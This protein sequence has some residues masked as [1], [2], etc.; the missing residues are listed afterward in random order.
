M[1]TIKSIHA[2]EIIDSRGYPTIEAVMVLDNGIESRTSVPSG[3]STGKYEAHELRDGD[4]NRM[5]GMGVLKAVDIINNLIGPKLV[6][7]NPADQQGIDTWLIQ[8]DATSRKER[9]GANTILTISQLCVK[10]AAKDNGLKTYAYVNAL[11]SKLYPQTAL[12]VTRIPTP[13]FNIINGGKHAYNTLDFQEFQIIPSSGLTFKAGYQLGVELFHELKKVLVYRNTAVSFGEE[14][15]Y[16]PNFTTNLDALEAIKE[17]VQ[18][19]NFIIGTDFF[20]G[21]DIASS[22]FYENSRYML[23]DK[24]QGLH[25]QEYFTYI[26]NMVKNYSILLLEDPFEDDDWQNWKKLTETSGEKMYIVGDD[27][28]TANK[29]RL[30]KAIAQKACNALLIK[31]NQ[32]GTI[33]ESFEVIHMARQ[34][35][36]SLIVSHRSGETNDDFIADFAVGL[37]SD[38][39][40]FGAPNRGERVAKYNRLLQ[41]E[42]EELGIK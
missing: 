40:K 4:P 38:F 24:P 37:Q 22:S 36:F 33:T 25:G 27:L 30:E 8:S 39:V 5:D 41:I 16:S 29:E 28:V 23:K 10:A 42:M 1:A 9:L 6:G 34:S 31:P 35:G 14:G 21:M 3:T 26:E 11:Y 32:I 12:T 13:V 20:F 7:A 18:R 15:G 19:R 17:A 2:Y